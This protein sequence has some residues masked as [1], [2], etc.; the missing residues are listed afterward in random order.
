MKINCIHCGHSFSLSDAYDDFEGPVKCP[1]CR[2]ML[3][4]KA[5]DATLKT[6]RPYSFAQMASPTMGSN[7]NSAT[8]T[9]GTFVL[10][11]AQQQVRAAAAPVVQPFHAPQTLGPVLP[12][13]Y[14]DP[15]VIGV[16]DG[17]Q[18]SGSPR[19]AA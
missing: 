9:G 4:I 19:V 2:G 13:S 17:T 16:V 14:P 10:S 6:V 3:E 15:N 12:T 7:S 5:Q 1:T 11:S 8:G 18:A